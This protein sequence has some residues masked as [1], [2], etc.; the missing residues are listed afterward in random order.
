LIDGVAAGGDGRA[1]CSLLVQGMEWEIW[2]QKGWPRP[3]N[4]K[5]TLLHGT[6]PLRQIK[7]K[8]TREVNNFHPL[9]VIFSFIGQY[10]C[11]HS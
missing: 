2:E 8:E 10:I 4:K 1:A 9:T 11:K 3:C 7:R 6:Q 5:K